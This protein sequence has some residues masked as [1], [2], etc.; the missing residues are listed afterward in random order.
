MHKRVQEVVVMI[1]ENYRTPLMK[2]WEHYIKEL[3]LDE[4][5]DNSG[6]KFVWKVTRRATT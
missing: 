5:R 1:K 2:T 6:I 4:H 3:F